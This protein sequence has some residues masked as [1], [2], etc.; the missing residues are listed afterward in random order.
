M[1]NLYTL[2]WQ[3]HVISESQLAPPCT[4]GSCAVPI[5][6][7]MFCVYLFGGL[8]TLERVFTNALWK[9]TNTAT[10]SSHGVRLNLKVK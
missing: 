8:N 1:Y 5:R 2:Q 3:K 10:E 9:L 4:A 7:E 6:E